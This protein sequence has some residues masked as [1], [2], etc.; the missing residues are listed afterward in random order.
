MRKQEKKIIKFDNNKKKKRKKE[1]EKKK[2]SPVIKKKIDKLRIMRYILKRKKGRQRIKC[3]KKMPEPGN[4]IY[5]T[6]QVRNQTNKQKRKNSKKSG[7]SLMGIPRVHY[8]EKK[9]ERTKM[10]TDYKRNK[11]A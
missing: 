6:E 9:L 10:K 8:K 3:Y 4:N 11:K 7:C 5:K 1:K 2:K